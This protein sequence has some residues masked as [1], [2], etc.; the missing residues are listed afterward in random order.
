MH[1]IFREAHGLEETETPTDLGQ[2]PAD[3]VVM[4]YSDSDLG[5]FA[6]G[7]RRAGGTLPTLRL[8][9][10]VALR[11]P[12]SVDVYLEKTLAGA[13]GIL[14]RLI[15]GESYWP[16][17]LA[18]LHDH[19]WR[20]DVALALL[21]AD[22]RPDA[23]LEELSTVPRATLHRLM[24]L[25][26]AGGAV[27]A[28]AALSQLALAA[29]LYAPPVPGSKRVPDHGWYDPEAGVLEAAPEA[30]GPRAVVTFYRS[31]LTAADLSP[32]DALIGAL[33]ERGFAAHGLF[34]GS[35]KAPGSAAWV[36]DELARSRP[37]AIV[38]ATAFSAQGA[39]GAPSPLDA[40]GCPVFQVALATNRRREWAGAARGL[41]PQDMAMHVVLPE[42]DGRVFA[43]VA[44]F[45][46]PE[47]RDPALQYSRFAHRAEPG[48]VAAI[49]DRVA[50]RARLA[51]TAPADRRLALI[52]S[53][54]PGRSDQAAHAVGL[55]ALASA[56]AIMGAL[57]GTGHDAPPPP[58]RLGPALLEAGIS[59]PVAEYRAALARLPE[60]LRAQLHAAW[61]APAD[62][63]AVRD[64]A[65]RFPALERGTTLIAL[66]PERGEV[67]A[68]E[69]E[70][71]D[72]ARTPRHGYVAFYLWLRAR[73]IDALIHVGAHGTLEWLPGKAVALSAECWPE[74]LTGATP[75]IYPFIVNDPGEA[76]EA[77]RRTGAVTL[78]HMP[79]PLVETRLAPHLARL[80]QLLDEY[81]TADG[82]DPRRRERLIGD[83]RAEA[84]AGG[85]ESDLNIPPDASAA[86]AIPR[87]DRFLCDLKESRY[88]DGLHV[89][90][91]GAHGA[92]E[93]AGLIAAVSGRHVAPGPAGSPDRGRADV[94]PTG[95]NLFSVDPR[96]VPTQAAHAEGVRL[97]GEMIRRHLQDQG[98]WP[99][100]VIVDLWA[101]ATM[102]TAGEEFAMAMHLAG[103]R[104]R[105]DAGSARVSGFE[106]M[107]LA[108]LGRPRIA[109]SLRVSGLFRD[110]F[111]TLVEMFEA[112]AVA[113]AGRE[114]EAAGD[115]P[116][117]GR[118]GPA[119][120]AP[121]PGLFGLGM[122]DAAH[123]FSDAGRD[124]AG[125]AWLAGTD[126]APGQGAGAGDA[127]AERVREAEAFVHVQD[128][129]ESDI[130]L[131][132]DYA[133]HEGG[134]AAARAHL[135]AAPAPAWHVDSTRPG[136][137]RARALPEEIARVVRTRAEDPGWV[138][139]MMRHGFRG[140]AEITATLDH[141]AAFANLTRAVPAHLFDIYHDATL[142]RDEV[143]DFMGHVNPRALAE[144]RARFE[145]LREAG[146]WRSRRNSLAVPEAGE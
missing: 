11:H 125:A 89:Y 5:A 48:R 74:A 1:V 62:D 129:A 49:A 113:L 26:D 23:R 92:E 142:G 108:E 20:N 126:W 2:D 36:A 21:P 91:T 17:G 99:R 61:G 109:V 122:G 141:L 41:S 22:G 110:S 131:A 117:P 69:D 59:W 94:L 118:A 140:A 24:A 72:L 87:I 18:Q 42:V 96:A 63:P 111:P 3:L 43:G 93:R 31:Y 130:L 144:L 29:G 75:V 13:R 56:R 98:D 135:G 76:A 33:R 58:D 112:L 146:L 19:A 137:P 82:L 127:F 83:I 14:V 134:F 124:A 128:L 12:L 47:P 88:G 100:E 54:Y 50:A 79:P 73:G 139:G 38:N 115:N 103:A 64:G 37:A 123:D 114:G 97:A 25:C 15:G 68:R 27:A 145:A 35:L 81:S 86:E 78:G 105:W 66:Q 119:V 120:F 143:C 101:S 65:F 32:V 132:A 39:D 6:A 40:A 57:A 104:P 136:A 80:E 90:G 52:L 7:W 51:A 85:V 138:D 46:A 71:H 121:R 4:S 34:A 28:Q 9:N 106:V 84:R 116:W 60:S 44:S 70:Y 16:Y 30:R 77:K 45:K 107:P 55:D 53:T 133:A 8:A 10:L 102:R 67:A 95:R